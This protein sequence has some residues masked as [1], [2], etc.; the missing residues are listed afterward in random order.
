MWLPLKKAPISKTQSRFSFLATCLFSCLH[1]SRKPWHSRWLYFIQATHA[2]ALSLSTWFPIFEAVMKARLVKLRSWI[3]KQLNYTLKYSFLESAQHVSRV[4]RGENL[5]FARTPFKQVSLSL[6][7]TTH[8]R[9]IE[10]YCVYFIV[11]KFVTVF[12]YGFCVVLA[13][14]WH[15]SLPRVSRGHEIWRSGWHWMSTAGQIYVCETVSLLFGQVSKSALKYI[16]GFPTRRGMCSMW[17]SE[18]TCECSSP[19]WR[20][21]TSTV[22]FAMDSWDWGWVN[23]DWETVMAAEKSELWNHWLNFGLSEPCNSKQWQQGQR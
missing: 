2:W 20:A 7:T 18:V 15:G 16:S 23:R 12:Y 5:H 19:V 11:W 9:Q 8:L 17:G 4:K 14:L 22:T 6:K 10:K 1:F 13:T 3:S 21:T